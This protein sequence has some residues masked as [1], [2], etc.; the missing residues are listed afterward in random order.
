MDSFWKKKTLKLLQKFS[1][2]Q[3]TGHVRQIGYT[4]YTGY[5]GYRMLNGIQD[6]Q[7]YLYTWFTRVYRVY[8]ISKVFKG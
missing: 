4:R 5:I 6:E 7:M 3:Y 1:A 8:N 2:T